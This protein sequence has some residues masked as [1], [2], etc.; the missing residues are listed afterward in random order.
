[1]PSAL[2]DNAGSTDYSFQ[3]PPHAPTSLPSSPTHLYTGFIVPHEQ[4]DALMD[5]QTE[6]HQG[7]GED[8][9]MEV[10]GEGQGEAG[11]VGEEPFGDVFPPERVGLDSE[12]ESHME[13]E[14]EA[15]TEG[16]MVGEQGMA[17][18][19]MAVE[20]T[21]ELATAVDATAVEATAEQATAIEHG[22]TTP[23]P[24]TLPISE[25]LPPDTQTSPAGSPQTNIDGESTSAAFVPDPV[26]VTGSPSLHPSPSQRTP[27]STS[28]L[29]VCDESVE[30]PAGLLVTDIE[31]CPPSSQSTMPSPSPHPDYRLLNPPHGNS[32]AEEGTTHFEGRIT[33]S[34]SRS[35]SNPPPNFGTPPPLMPRKSS[36]KPPSRK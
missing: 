7:G 36:W 33:C 5:L 26:A 1:M 4:N 16:E 6:F 19:A 22:S 21:V 28:P 9:E 10:E 8:M 25:D 17:D 11:Q 14:Q 15:A 2:V 27:L 35:I 32:A 29:L 30:P 31:V 18:E 13:T 3:E 34:R 23:V 12:E 20:A 24:V